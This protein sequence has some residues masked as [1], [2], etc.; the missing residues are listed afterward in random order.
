MLNSRTAQ[1]TGEEE[2]ISSCARNIISNGIITTD[3]RFYA[4]YMRKHNEF[5]KKFKLLLDKKYISKESYENRR[6]YFALCEAADC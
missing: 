6:H 1:G 4:A 5:D 2:D 3:K